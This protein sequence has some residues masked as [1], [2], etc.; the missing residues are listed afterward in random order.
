MNIVRVIFDFITSAR[1]SVTP[2]I[3]VLCD[4]FVE[5]HRLTVLCTMCLC[6]LFLTLYSL[7]S[8]ASTLFSVP[9]TLCKLCSA[10]C[11]PALYSMTPA[12]YSMT[13]ALCRKSNPSPHISWRLGNT[14][15]PSQS[16]ANQSE[17]G[18][19]KWRSEASLSHR[20]L[21]KD[22]G[23]FSTLSASSSLTEG[24]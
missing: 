6:L 23:R 22:I 20:F 13:P 18:S 9:P 21:K 3:Y 4:P 19:T 10:L 7:C 16:Q 8:M 24:T 11:D 1:Y 12:L 14:L 2:A 5:L 17:P 15:L